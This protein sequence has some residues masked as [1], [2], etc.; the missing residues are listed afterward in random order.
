LAYH[1]DPERSEKALTMAKRMR[2]ASTTVSALGWVLKNGKPH[3]G[4]YGSPESIADPD[5]REYTQTFGMRAHF[6]L[7]LLARGRIIGV[8]AIIQAES[9]RDISEDDRSLT[10]ELGR[11][12]ALALDNA[13]LYAD[14]ET[15]RRQA[16][17]ANRAKDEF[18]AMLGHELR[19]PLAPIS[20]ALELM[21][22]RHPDTAVEERRVI[23]R[24][25]THMS[26]LIDDLLDISRITQGK[27]QLRKESVDLRTVVANALEL[28]KPVF[29][30]HARPVEVHVPDAPAM[31]EGD[32]VRL[33][34]VVGNLLVN[35]AKFTPAAGRVALLLAEHDGQFQLRVEDSGSG[36]APDLLPR[37]F[38]LFVQGRQRIDRR[39]G[40]LGLGL[41]IVRSLVELHGGTVKAESAG[42]GQ[43]SR[44]TVSLPAGTGEAAETTEPTRVAGE[45]S[46]R[47]LVVDDNADAADT[48][49]ELLR[50]CGYETRTAAD[51]HEALA[52]L[53]DF[54]PA[55]ALLDIG[56][57]G[58]DGYE[59]AGM[60]RARP[61]LRSMKLVALTGYGRD[62][63]RALAENAGFDEHL[64]KPVDLHKLL[65]VLQEFLGND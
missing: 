48:L 27:V 4:D 11:R 31:V 22:R 16:E 45:R 58:V 42:E 13:R 51:A 53:D 52:I 1:I 24:Q 54:K 18:L 9:G 35:A 5:L 8:M 39:G 28:T 61:G 26:R 7:P 20:T 50:M 37:V 60:I 44:F 56:L 38:D 34:Q 57:P 25:V 43:G 49:A 30:D 12:A 6:I 47:I 14:A 41:A 10:E 17:R 65:Q 32:A 40:G 64:V 23:A 2:A 46:G 21:A 19:N 3:Y 33:A 36:I 59:L 15:A 62:N 63:D 55:L 29:N